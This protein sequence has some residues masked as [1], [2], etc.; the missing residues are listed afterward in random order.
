MYYV[1]MFCYVVS[2]NVMLSFIMFCFLPSFLSSSSLFSLLLLLLSLSLLSLSLLSLCSFASASSPSLSTII[3]LPPCPLSCPPSPC[4]H[5]PYAYRKSEQHQPERDHFGPK[6]TTITSQK[7]QDKYNLRAIF[8]IPYFLWK[9]LE[10]LSLYIAA[11]SLRVSGVI[12]PAL[13]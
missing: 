8:I 4:T 9:L 11:A 12:H 13:H 3:Y 10:Y 7:T 5:Y 2:Y 1:V 6:N